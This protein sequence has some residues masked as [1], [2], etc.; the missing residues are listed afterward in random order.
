MVVSFEYQEYGYNDIYDY[1]FDITYEPV[2]PENTHYVP[3]ELNDKTCFIYFSG[4]G[5]D[6]GKIQK[7]GDLVNKYVGNETLEVMNVEIDIDEDLSA[8]DKLMKLAQEAKKLTAEYDSFRIVFESDR[9]L[10]GWSYVLEY[11]CVRMNCLS[12]EI[13]ENYDPETDILPPRFDLYGSDRIELAFEKSEFA[14]EEIEGLIFLA[15]LC[16]KYPDNIGYAD[17]KYDNYYNNRLFIP[18]LYVS[19]DF[20][21]K[22][23]KTI[24]EYID[25]TFQDLEMTKSRCIVDFSG[26]GIKIRYG[27]V[28]LPV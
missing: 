25:A 4:Y 26:N 17:Y 1:I 3:A 8:Y 19:F 20:E 21:D 27:G 23:Y 14:T 12:T 9:S 22:G 28:N 2:K 7:Y 16:N 11:Y 13:P 5:A 6:D 24:Y 15:L 18:F 10:S